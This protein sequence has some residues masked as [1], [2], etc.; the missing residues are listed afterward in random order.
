MYIY[1]SFLLAG[2]EKSDDGVAEFEVVEFI[3]I[4]GM[5]SK[6]SELGSLEHSVAP[7]TIPRGLD[8]KMNIMYN[9]MG[10][11][12]EGLNESLQV[13]ALSYVCWILFA[14]VVLYCIDIAEEKYI[15]VVRQRTML[16]LLCIQSL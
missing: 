10:I 5:I 11:V 16:S 6:T 8:E 14:A 9:E 12:L 3:A 15:F 13:N 7:T 2:Y 4:G 1:L